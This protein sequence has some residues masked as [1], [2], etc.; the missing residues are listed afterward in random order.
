MSYRVAIDKA[1]C[2]SSGQCV[3][4]APEG[5][6][7]DDDELGDVLPGASD[8]PLERLRAAAVRCPA[9]AIAIFDE[10]GAEIDVKR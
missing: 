1:I 6:G 9:I 8:L 4:E 3:N 10:T 7:F 2:Q 5:F